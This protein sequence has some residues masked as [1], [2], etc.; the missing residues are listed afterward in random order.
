M[1]G[2]KSAVAVAWDSKNDYIYWSDVDRN[3]LNRVFWNGSSQ[4]I[5]VHSNISKFG[6]VS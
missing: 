2:I 3:S 5:L 4:E 1:D 6:C